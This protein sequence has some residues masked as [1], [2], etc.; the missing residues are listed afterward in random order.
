[1]TNDRNNIPRRAFIKASAG[2]AV[3]AAAGSIHNAATAAVPGLMRL[4]GPVSSGAGPDEWIKNLKALGYRAA[5]CPIGPKAKDDAKK[6]DIAIAEVGAWSNPISPNN[7]ERK[8][9][10]KKCCDQLALAERIG[11]N[12]CVNISGSRNPNNWAGPH[13]DNFTKETFDMI[14][15]TTR[16]I[17]DEIK[18]ARTFFCL[19]TMPWAYPDS[20]ESYLALVRAIDRKQCAVHFDPVNLVCSPQRY[21]KNG[22]LIREC[23]RKLG[24]LMKSCHAKDIIL[25]EKFTTHLD[26]TRPGLGGLDYSV[27]LTELSKIPDLPL[28]L[29]HLPNQ[30]E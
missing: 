6:A 25:S 1:M 14:V 19:E 8:A 9:A 29:E 24:P 17:I 10:H 28:M 20:A 5:Y 2:A 16:S 26:E 12:C 3:L 13:A 22:A 30:Q 18:P 4:G 21:Y 7:D 27:F 11:A 15:E 23:F